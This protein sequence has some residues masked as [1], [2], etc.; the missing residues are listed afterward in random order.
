[1]ATVKHIK[2]KNQNYN[3]AVQYLTYQHNEFTNKPILDQN[4]NM[5]LRGEYLIDGINCSPLSF[6]RECADVNRSFNKNT[7]FNEIKAHHYIISFDPRDKEENGL[8]TEKAQALGI[9]IAEKM[10]PGHQIIVCTHPDGHNNAGNIHCHI[11]LNSVR[12]FTVDRREFMHLKSDNL[13]GYKH[14]STKRFLQALKQEVMDV[15]Q[16][17][18]LYQID[19]ISPAKV[20][21]TDKEYWA[22]KKGQLQIESSNPANK[23]RPTVRFET[24]KNYLRSIITSI[25]ID[26]HSLE[27][28]QHK[29]L[30][31]YGVEIYESHNI[32]Y[33]SVPDIS[34]PISANSLG[35]DYG[36]AFLNDYYNL[37]LSQS[38]SQ[39]QSQYNNVQENPLIAELQAFI[40]VHE[41]PYYNRKIK[42]NDLKKLSDALIFL[43]EN[44]IATEHE[45][46]ALLDS[47]KE[48]FQQKQE[49]LKEA[50]T[51][52]RKINKLIHYT[53]Q[54]FSTKAIY[55]Q[56]LQAYNKA[57]FRNY[58]SQ[59][60]SI[61]ETS[62]R[63]LKT[64]IDDGKI[65]SMKSLKEQ[66]QKLVQKKNALYE[67]YSHYKALFKHIRNIE[68]ITQQSSLNHSPK[69]I[70]NLKQI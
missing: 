64:I 50:E 1:M 15:C 5:I 28:F 38:L 17:E 13:A 36:R 56:Y 18:K 63:E 43:Q 2:I 27:E 23:T 8:T 20:K 21:V 14:H 37:Q 66:K 33:Y 39:Q 54:Y 12:K 67:E 45:F 52:L 11:V 31:R 42:I 22:Q 60:L 9:E 32:Y 69:S 59:D 70:V 53:G 40:K 10:F 62:R 49:Q 35:T 55:Q 51:E 44:N 30:E 34:K 65:S 4:G 29:L 19:L 25:M 68:K 46:N 48:E 47:V 58:H 24:N 6:G 16:R 57:E 26:S 7:G 61:Y 3:A 41:N